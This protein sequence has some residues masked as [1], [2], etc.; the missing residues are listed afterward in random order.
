MTSTV[1]TQNV[2]Y[3]DPCRWYVISISESILFFSEARTITSGNFVYFVDLSRSEGKGK[4]SLKVKLLFNCT[5][6]EY[7][8]LICVM[9]SC[10]EGGK[11]KKN[12]K[13]KIVVYAQIVLIL[14][15][16]LHFTSSFHYIK[17]EIS[18]LLLHF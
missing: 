11:G 10:I 5:S 8:K 14:N 3:F 17:K 18:L 2:L 6:S 7:N 4:L 1:F 9:C 15:I 13:I 16:L 12:S